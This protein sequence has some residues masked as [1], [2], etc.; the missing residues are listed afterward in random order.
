MSQRGTESGRLVITEDA[1]DL[2][3]APDPTRARQPPQPTRQRRVKKRYLAAG[4]SVLALVLLAA[5]SELLL[6]PLAEKRIHT[7]IAKNGKDVRVRVDAEPAVKL[8]FGHADRIDVKIGELRSGRGALADRLASTAKTDRLDATVATLLTHGLRLEHVSLRKRGANLAAGASV[9]PAS[10]RA[11]L[12]SAINVDERGAGANTL[13][14]TASVRTFGRVVRVKALVRAVDG[15]ILLQPDSAL[16][17]VLHVT[18]F[19]DPRV[20]V[21]VID[22]ARTPDGRYVFA[23][24]GHLE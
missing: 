17:A 8:L 15:R 13:V 16:G 21:D 1:L 18:L 10:V 20:Y 5:L 9:T 11:V 22:S 23:A 4:L 24:R 6:P 2:A 3:D 7:R 14:V 19:G 12:P